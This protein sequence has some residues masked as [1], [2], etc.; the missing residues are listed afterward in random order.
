MQTRDAVRDFVCLLQLRTYYEPSAQSSTFAT[1]FGEQA[2]TRI[3][4]L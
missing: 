4:A 1:L 2:E 3:S